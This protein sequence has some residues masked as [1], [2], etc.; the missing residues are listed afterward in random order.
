MGCNVAAGY[1]EVDLGIDFYGYPQYAN[2]QVALDSTTDPFLV[3][4]QNS[5]AVDN[6]VAPA[7][8]SNNSSK[9]VFGHVGAT[10]PLVDLSGGPFSVAFGA[11]Y[12]TRDQYGVAPADEANGLYPSGYISNNFSVGKQYVYSGYV[13]FD[14]PIVKQLDIDLA[15]RYDHYNLSGGKASPKIGFKYTPV[16]SFAVRGTAAKGFRAPGPQ[17]NGESGQTLHSA[18]TADPILFESEQ[19][20]RRRQLRRSVLADTADSAGHESGAEAGNL[21]D[22]Y[23][24]FPVPAD[25]RFQRGTGPVRHRDRQPDR[26]RRTDHDGARHEPGATAGVSAWW[27]HRAGDPTGGSI[28]YFATS[29]INANSA[30][31]TG[32]DLELDYHHRF[33]WFDFK[34]VAM[35]NYDYRY[36][37]RVDGIDYQLAGTHGPSGTGADTGNPRTHIQWAKPP[38]SARSRSPAR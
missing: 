19:Y 35:W 32:F 15:T 20:D 24:G 29:Y 16:D 7:E 10:R 5:P 9:L 31:T 3:G 6:F 22:L 2:L 26:Q 38:R 14:A 1:S 28:A 4:Q 37:M 30:K 11:D 17:E 33:D 25:A 12:Y 27:R 8:H 13:E 18:A 21:Q 34:S 23:A 36:T